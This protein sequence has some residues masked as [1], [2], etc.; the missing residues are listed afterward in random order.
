MQA[1]EEIL[2]ILLANGAHVLILLLDLSKDTYIYEKRPTKE[3]SQSKRYIICEKIFSTYYLQSE[4][5][6]SYLSKDT[7]VN[8]DNY[9]WKETY[10]RDLHCMRKD[11]L[12]V[13]L[14]SGAQVFVLEQKYMCQKIPLYM[15]RDQ[16][17]WPTLYAK[18][19]SGRTPGT[20]SAG[21]RTWATTHASKETYVFENT[22][23]KETYTIYSYF[24]NHIYVKRDINIWN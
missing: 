10:K 24:S 7:C 19:Y 13:L 18:N 9:I 8:K 22:P 14:A 12:S 21:P 4:H 20:W 17:K 1:N 23:T 11:I 2:D 15:K 6:Y 3:T 5:R 16:Q